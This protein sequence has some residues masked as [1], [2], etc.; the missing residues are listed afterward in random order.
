MSNSH[1]TYSIPLNSC[2]YHISQNL[3]D[4]DG[5]DL[6]VDLH[7]ELAT[8]TSLRNV[9]PML[10]RYKHAIVKIKALIADVILTE[11]T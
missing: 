7:C 6:F 2:T 11:R 10:T 9:Y 1:N 3:I 8:P 4:T 5:I